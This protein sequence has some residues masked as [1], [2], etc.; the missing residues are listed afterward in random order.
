MGKV[1]IPSADDIHAEMLLEI[2]RLSSAGPPAMMLQDAGLAATRDGAVY[3]PALLGLEGAAFVEVMYRAVLGRR[4][5]PA[6][7]QAYVQMLD[8]G[9]DKTEIIRRVRESAEGVRHDAELI[10]LPPPG[11]LDRLYALPV[12]GRRLRAWQV[13]FYMR[14][15]AREVEALRYMVGTLQDR[16]NAQQLAL[17]ALQA[18]QDVSPSQGQMRGVTA[19]VKELEQSVRP[20]RASP[21]SAPIA[22]LAQQQIAADEKL[23][24]FRIALK[25]HQ[26]EP[27]R[28]MDVA[29]SHRL[30]ALY[31]AFEAAFRGSR[32]LI[33]ERQ[34]VHL[35]V[36]IAANAGTAE[37]PIIDVGAG[38][39]E[40]L[41]LLR[42]AGLVGR[43]IDLN[44][45]MVQS[46]IA[47][48]LDCMLGDAV[49]MLA[50]LP[51][52][53][54]GAVTGFHIIEHLPFA[55]MVALFD[56][57]L[58][59]L[60]PDGVV[61]FETPNPANLQVGS[62][63]FYLDPTHRNPL[64]SEMVSMIAQ[65]RGFKDVRILPLHPTGGSFEAQDAKLGAQLDALLH[66]PMDYALIAYKA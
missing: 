8:R 64:P 43:G 51:E 33:K 15:P 3:V 42:E 17:S 14:R 6:G 18:R 63:S 50:Q 9:V 65:A 19:L 60:A 16:C 54:L 40:W 20:L 12:I 34:R 46:C 28:N 45:A 13:K 62:R 1:T 24:S 26:I 22:E 55:T 29:D 38:R 37:R 23:E 11:P 57:A 5:D 27:A 48:G 61:L 36:M 31:V 2:S 4:A 52:N 66:G 10:G 41:E 7:L 25:D 21:W 35:P 32:A 58:R 30:D 56:A 59:V 44:V 49:A 53:S 47:L 39:G